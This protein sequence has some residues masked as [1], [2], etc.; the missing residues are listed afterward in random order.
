MY[1]QKIKLPA[2]TSGAGIRVYMASLTVDG[3]HHHADTE[4]H[5]KLKEKAAG[6]LIDETMQGFR[7]VG[8]AADKRTD[9]LTVVKGHAELLKML[10]KPASHIAGDRRADA[11]AETAVDHID[12]HAQNLNHWQ[13]FATTSSSILICLLRTTG[14]D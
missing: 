14:S 11:A 6:E 10:D 5:Q 8:D 2:M 7:V 3:K 9:L 13:E 12:A 1:R 4:N